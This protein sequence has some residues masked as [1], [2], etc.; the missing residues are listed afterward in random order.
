MLKGSGLV[1]EEYRKRKFRDLARTW[2]Q[3]KRE[4]LDAIVNQLEPRPKFVY[5]PFDHQL[6]T[7]L[8]ALKY[9]GLVLALDMG[10]GKSKIVLDV[11]S[12]RRRLVSPDQRA[13][14]MLVLVPNRSNVWSWEKQIEEHAPWLTYGLLSDKVSGQRRREIWNDTTL[15]VVVATYAGM[16]AIHKKASEIDTKLVTRTGSLFDTI[17]ADESSYLRNVDSQSFRVL[18]QLAHHVKFR[19]PMTGT[20]FTKDALGLWSQFFFADPAD[21]PLT[22]SFGVFR[23]LFFTQIKLAFKTEFSLNHD[24]RETLHRVLKHLSIRYEE[25]ECNSLPEKM[26][27]LAKPICIP[28][29]M[30][31]QQTNYVEQT[32]QEARE[33][34]KDDAVIAGAFHRVRRAASGYVE[35]PGTG[36]F[37]YFTENPKLEACIDLLREM[38]SEQCIVVSYYQETVKMI[39]KRLR[40]EHAKSHG[41]K[42]TYS[43]VVG[44]Q[45]DS[46]KQQADFVSG[47]TRIMLLSSFPLWFVCTCR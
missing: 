23:S 24:K 17:V 7:F 42:F 12:Y 3:L 41:V 32:Y 30:H 14:R 34:A 10:T 31:E 19:Y 39:E 36:E 43:K 45:A 6:V 26:G 9:P 38:G 46:A 33:A 29:H 1:V 11:F 25:S 22:S 8:L 28:A 21:S 5:P 40:E 37:K 2:K 18:S 20:P 13:R 4:Q 27:G 35:I 47:K 16:L 44:K 15:N